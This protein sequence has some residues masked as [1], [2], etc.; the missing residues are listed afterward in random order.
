M[1]AA[2]KTLGEQVLKVRSKNAGPFW[3]TIDIFCGS[4]Q[5]YASI[6]PRVR[7]ADVGRLYGT[8]EQ[9]VKRFDIPD[10]HVIK[11]SIPRPVVQGAAAD[12]DM[13]GAQ[14]AHLLDE[15]LV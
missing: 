14:W 12:R 4:P 3:V 13:H 8:P 6:L 10:L 15:M 7:T 2:M 1:T 9:L 5:A 11:F